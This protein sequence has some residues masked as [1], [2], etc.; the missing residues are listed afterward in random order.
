MAI[1]YGAEEISVE[2]LDDGRGMPDTMGSGFGITG[3]RER[4]SLLHGRFSAGP[5]PEGG[6]RVAAEL[7]LPVGA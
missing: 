2:V 1:D 6:F 3:M 7:P 4:V 5:R